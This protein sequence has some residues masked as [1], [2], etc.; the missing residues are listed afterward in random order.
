MD[1]EQLITRHV[2]SIDNTGARIFLVFRKIPDD[3]SHCLVIMADA[4]PDQYSDNLNGLV[5]SREAQNT[6]EL[7]E[8]LHRHQ[9]A[10][11]SNVLA[12]VHEKGFLKRIPIENV[13]MMP[14]PDRLIPLST[15][16][17]EIDGTEP[18]VVATS[19]VAEATENVDDSAARVSN[20]LAQA[21]DLETQARALREQAYQIDP[22][23]KKA[24]R[25]DS[26]LSKEEKNEKRNAKRR[27]DYKAK[28][29]AKKEASTS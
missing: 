7:S 4:L 5:Y 8:V 21:N 15:I 20:M 2:G 1:I 23:A 6:V 17:A 22:S 25:P 9:F 27:A 12:T 3:D 28:Q 10:D 16:N 24:G 29:A 11:G 26:G 14:L 13:Q 19:E 18:Q